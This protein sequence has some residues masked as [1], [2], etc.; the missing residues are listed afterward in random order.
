M[1]IIEAEEQ[2]A[3]ER[4]IA[5]FD[6]PKRAG[7]TQSLRWN[8]RGSYG[9]VQADCGWRQLLASSA[10]EPVTNCCAIE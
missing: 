1:L 8:G 3:V 6:A 10:I 5:G 4:G 9:F 2:I 7:T